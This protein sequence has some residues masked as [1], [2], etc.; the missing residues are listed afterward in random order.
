SEAEI[1]QQLADGKLQSDAFVCRV[2]SEDWMR[3]SELPEFGNPKPANGPPHTPPP[4]PDTPPAPKPSWNPLA[5][6]WLGL[7]FTP[8]W[9]GIMAAIN[10]KRLGLSL[11]LWRPLAIG[12]GS[13]V[14]AILAAIADWTFG[15]VIDTLIFTVAPLIAIWSLDLEPQMAAHRARHQPTQD[16]WIGPVLAG[17]PLAL[18][19]IVGWW[20]TL[21]APLEPL[22]VVKRFEQADT[23]GEAREYVT[24]NLFSMVDELKELEKLDPSLSSDEDGEIEH[25]SDYPADGDDQQ[26][27]VEYRAY[28]PAQSG[29]PAVR[30]EGYYHLRQM[31]GE[32][33]IDDWVVTSVDG[34]EPES[35]PISFSVIVSEMLKEAKQNAANQQKPKP[36]WSLTK[37]WDRIP[38]NL[39]RLLAF[40]AVMAAL[41]AFQAVSKN[42]N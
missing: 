38:T 14:A 2:G 37:L 23:A 41:G 29:E 11:P 17:S 28:F 42:S 24:S 6:T 8:M 22:E 5:I 27:F 16:H 32:W 39:K 31:E 21:F 10:I 40:A 9:T 33:K 13:M 1:K 25:L 3:L 4:P 18:L 30:G 26:Y 7:L 12:I 34:Q 20:M 36:S 19:T 15:T 35:G